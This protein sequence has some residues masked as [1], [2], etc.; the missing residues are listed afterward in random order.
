MCVMKREKL[1][2]VHF[3]LIHKYIKQISWTIYGVQER[4]KEIIKYKP[5]SYLEK[6]RKKVEKTKCHFARGINTYLYT[7]NLSI[8]YTHT[9][10]DG[11]SD[12][13]WTKKR[14]ISKK[15]IK[16]I[17]TRPVNIIVPPFPNDVTTGNL[18]V[19]FVCLVSLTFNKYVA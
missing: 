3:Y 8:L 1:I 16:E 4:K 14:N 11:R 17:S 2:I 19:L 5:V 9:Y 6:M 12:E 7:W 15:Y 10:I 18:Y 13:K